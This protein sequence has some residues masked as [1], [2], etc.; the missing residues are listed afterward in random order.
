MKF[1]VLIG[2][3]SLFVQIFLVIL[4]PVVALCLYHIICPLLI[5]M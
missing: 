5:S 2:K 3:W 4:S 1:S